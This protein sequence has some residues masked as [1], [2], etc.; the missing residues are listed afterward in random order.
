MN[1]RYLGEET[2]P[3]SPYLVY[4]LDSSPDNLAILLKHLLVIWKIPVTGADLVNWVIVITAFGKILT[5]L[6][7]LRE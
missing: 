6:R 5:E 4:F 3:S 1:M 2:P 7:E